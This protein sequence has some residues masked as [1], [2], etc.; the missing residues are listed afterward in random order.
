MMLAALS[1][2][3]GR[4]ATSLAMNAGAAI[5]LAGLAQSHEAGLPSTRSSRQRCSPFQTRSF[6]AYTQK[7]NRLSHVSDILQKNPRSETR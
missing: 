5:Y 3:A 1:N 7:S 2:Q 6:I 4:P